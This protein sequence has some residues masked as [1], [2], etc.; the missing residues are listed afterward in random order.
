[1][2]RRA[3]R[4]RRAAPQ[5]HRGGPQGRRQRH[6][7]RNECRRNPV[8]VLQIT[9]AALG[10]CDAHPQRQ[11]RVEHLTVVSTFAE[12]PQQAEG[13]QHC[14]PDDRA[15]D[16]GHPGDRQEREPAGL[17]VAGMWPGTGDNGS[18]DDGERGPHDHQSKPVLGARHHG[19]DTLRV[20]G[21][22]RTDDKHHGK[23]NQHHR[24][25]EV[26]L[27][28]DG[29]QVC[30][31]DDRTKDPLSWDTSD[32]R[33]RQPLQ[34]TTSRTPH[35]CA[36]RGEHDGKSDDEGEQPVDL[37]D[38]GMLRRHVDQLRV[39]AIRPVVAPEPRA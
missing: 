7:Q 16:A 22:A 8:G 33:N 37:F 35:K 3:A 15:V 18:G 14:N 19:A 13:H 20:V 11:R 9:D 30:P 39:V 36:E 21:L 25:H 23:R 2:L 31:H 32:Q 10:D 5:P 24:Q 4:S 26:Q 34:I 27:H 1:M 12:M 38:G 17:V 29:I 28:R 6:M